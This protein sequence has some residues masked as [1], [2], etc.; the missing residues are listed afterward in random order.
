MFHHSSQ[1]EM[2][3]IEC[4][5]MAGTSQ[6]LAHLFQWCSRRFQSV[7]HLLHSSYHP[8]SLPWLLEACQSPGCY[9]L[10]QLG[11]LSVVTS[12]V[13]VWRRRGLYLIAC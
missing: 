2:A 9:P 6:S 11:Q 10:G 3:A 1:S 4:I 8:S 12:F 5:G 7:L 13:M